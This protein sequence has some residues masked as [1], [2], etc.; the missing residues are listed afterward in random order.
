MKTAPIDHFSFHFAGCTLA[1]TGPTKAQV[2]CQK[3]QRQSIQHSTVSCYLAEVWLTKMI[4]SSTAFWLSPQGTCAQ[5]R[6]SGRL[7]L[8]YVALFSDC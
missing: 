6:K 8:G 7:R 5:L 1:H 4:L 2:R 3:N